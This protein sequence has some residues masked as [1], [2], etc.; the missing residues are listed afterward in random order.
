[1]DP[2]EDVS[3]DVCL[4]L[5]VIILARNIAN[6]IVKTVKDISVGG[7]TNV[8]YDVSVIKE[9][10]YCTK[11]SS[12]AATSALNDVITDLINDPQNIIDTLDFDPESEKEKIEKDNQTKTVISDVVSSYINNNS[13]ISLVV[14][15][16]AYDSLE[17]DVALKKL[18]ANLY[19]LRKNTTKSSI[20]KSSC[21]RILM[22]RIRKTL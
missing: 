8:N 14:Y 12:E 21:N 20:M 1:M 4:L 10:M 3:I 22:E 13:F 18:M 17:G 19:S 5:D 11:S 6:D 15:G 7:G 2:S 16:D 9:I